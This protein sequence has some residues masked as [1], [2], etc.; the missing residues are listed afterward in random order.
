[1]GGRLWGGRRNSAAG[2]A[3]PRDY[4]VRYGL[5]PRARDY[6]RYLEY[7]G[8]EVA[9]ESENRELPLRADPMHWHRENRPRM[10]LTFKRHLM[11]HKLE[12]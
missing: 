2:A 12:K 7:R 11:G 6:A 5:V 10:R 3:T 4:G 8:Q 9:L 1:V